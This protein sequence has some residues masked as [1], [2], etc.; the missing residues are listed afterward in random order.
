M[1]DEKFGVWAIR[2]FVALVGGLFGL[3][4]V[5]LMLRLTIDVWL[6]IIEAL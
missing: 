3:L 4:M 6:Y 1:I 5:A 2:I